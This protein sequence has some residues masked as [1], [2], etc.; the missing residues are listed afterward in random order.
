MKN[1]FTIKENSSF[2]R[3]QVD[4]TSQSCRIPIAALFLSYKSKE[5]ISH[6]DSKNVKILLFHYNVIAL[7]TCIS[8]SFDLTQLKMF[9]SLG[10]VVVNYCLVCDC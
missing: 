10:V 8:Y 6:L 7:A 4:I 9:A 5:L 1:S 2:H 3:I